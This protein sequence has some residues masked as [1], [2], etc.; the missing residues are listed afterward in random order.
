LAR[1]TNVVRL[2]PP[3]PAPVSIS[4]ARALWD[5]AE[6]R[7]CLDAVRAQE[8]PD[9][10]ILASRCLLRLGR[11]DEAL[12]RLDAAST[13]VA[14]CSDALRG[15]HAIVAANMH[16]LS[17]NAD[18]SDSALCEARA[19]IFS[20]R[21]SMLEAE[22]NVVESMITWGRGELR[23]ARAIA[24]HALA[25]APTAKWRARSL[26]MLGVIA[27]TEGKYKNQITL[28]ERAL[29]LLDESEAGEPWLRGAL[30]QV[31]AELCSDLYHHDIVSRL[32]RREASLAWTSDTEYMHFTTL[33][34][35]ARCHALSGDH[36]RAFRL[37]RQAADIAP[38]LPWRVLIF[39]ERSS[40]AREMNERLFAS[41]ELEQAR[42][43]AATYN[44]S[45]TRGEERFALLR[46]AEVT[47]PID[48]AGAQDILEIYRKKLPPIAPH[49]LDANDGR[50]GASEA[51]SF[52]ITALYLG[53]T[54]RAIERLTHAFSVWRGIDYVW[55]AM[56]VAIHLTRLTGASVFF[57]YA[58]RHAPTFP[59]TWL[60]SE[61]AR[62]Q[63]VPGNAQSSA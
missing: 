31:L 63:A 12:A 7:A 17:G 60:A 5:R 2:L 40:L 27:G 4:A 50:L 37:L 21:D 3:P 23:R 39:A 28:Y 34:H 36:L 30:L 51:Y 24:E 57:E 22:L 38:S 48:A 52:G 16:F 56:D 13:L 9:A 58:R 11:P 54:T 20:A 41:E 49:T 32:S 14:H 29:T 19:Y 59:G 25:V 62:L 10:A 26:E 55:R 33:R 61:V 15:E 46:L 42:S 6:I 1:A 45:Q 35:I 44:W 47:A 8:S 53:D 43:I 18:L